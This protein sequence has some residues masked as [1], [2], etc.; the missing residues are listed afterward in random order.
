[1]RRTDGIGE[2]A[3]ARMEGVGSLRREWLSR[4]AA[5]AGLGL[6]RLHLQ[7]RKVGDRAGPGEFGVIELGS[8]ASRRGKLGEWHQD[9]NEVP[10]SSGDQGAA[11]DA[12]LDPAFFEEAYT[13]KLFGH[14]GLCEDGAQAAADALVEGAPGDVEFWWLH[15]SRARGCGG[16]WGLSQ[17]I[18]GLKDLVQIDSPVSIIARCAPGLRCNPTG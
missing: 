6:R 13:A 18:G 7:Q 2:D 9:K 15:R 5:R 3:L 14:F 4:L 10:Q 1:M 16:R 11:R 17:E 12:A 8:S